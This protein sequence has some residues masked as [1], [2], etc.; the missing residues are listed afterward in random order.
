MRLRTEWPG[1]LRW[2][3]DG[4]L[5]WQSNGLL[6][7]KIVLEATAEYF[8][9]QDMI[10][11]WMDDEC[12]HGSKSYSDTVA[13]LFKSWSDFAVANGEK[14]GSTKW[15]AQS[16]NRQGCSPLKNTPGS[17]GKRGFEGI[18]VKPVDTSKQWQNQE[19]PSAMPDF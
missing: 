9:E 18:Q 16:L 3:I 17:N 12:D 11:Q 14:P 7:P 4:C 8:S 15:F 5:D 2:M 13:R 19:P 10:R 6:R 1:I